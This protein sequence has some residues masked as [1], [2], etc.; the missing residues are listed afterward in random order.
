[1]K[2]STMETELSTARRVLQQEFLALLLSLDQSGLKLLLDEICKSI[3]KI[4]GIDAILTCIEDSGEQGNKAVAK[5]CCSLLSKL[6]G[7]DTNKSE[8][9]GKGGIDKLIKLS[10]RFNDDPFVLQE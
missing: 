4:G 5:V 1:W 6:A 10:T 7:S 3:S 8:I 2:L 9:V